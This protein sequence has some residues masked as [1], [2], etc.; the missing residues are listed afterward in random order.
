MYTLLF[1]KDNQQKPIIWHMALCSMLYASL[2]GRDLGGEWIHVHVGLSSL[3]VHLK[4]SPH[5]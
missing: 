2:D 4:L 1:K 3:A 5:C